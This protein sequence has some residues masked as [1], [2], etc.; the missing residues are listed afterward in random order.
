MLSG[1]SPY[2]LSYVVGQNVVAT[3]GTCRS[4]RKIQNF[5]VTQMNTWKQWAKVR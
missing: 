2:D 4:Y 5:P 1:V 3:E